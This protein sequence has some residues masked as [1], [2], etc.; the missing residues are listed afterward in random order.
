MRAAV[1]KTNLLLASL[2]A[3][4]LASAQ[5]W[6][7]A[8]QPTTSGGTNPSAGGTTTSPEPVSALLANA[9]VDRG[10]N[11]A[12]A[13]VACH[14][15]EKG[16]AN[17]IGPNLYNSVGS[18]KA[19]HADFD[20]SPA[21]KK[22]EGEWDYE[23]LNAYLWRPAVYAKGT[24]MVYAGLARPQD[25][26]DVIAYMRSM[27]DNPP[28]LPGVT[29]ASAGG[30]APTS[31][32]TPPGTTS[33]GSGQSNTGGSRASQGAGSGAAMP[34]GSGA[35]ATGGGPTGAAPTGGPV[36]GSGTSGASAGS[37]GGT[38]TSTTDQAKPPTPDA[39]ASPGRSSAEP[40]ASVT[41]P[42]QGAVDK[43]RMTGPSGTPQK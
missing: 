27:H 16:G 39:N 19:S 17:R 28:P 41:V 22:L 35:S 6:A 37:A 24:K 43:S 18:D 25:R 8:N 11:V 5:G 21:L 10:K 15:F 31:T 33:G 23:S 34:G 38:S 26:A 29:P 4:G 20:F 3:T 12:R 1:R 40:P 2:L 30:S 42:T 9:S 13:C 7:A 32:P 36:A 14:T